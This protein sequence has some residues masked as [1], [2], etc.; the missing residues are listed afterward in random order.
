[1]EYD[2]SSDPFEFSGGTHVAASGKQSHSILSGGL[3]YKELELLRVVKVVPTNQEKEVNS[4]VGEGTPPTYTAMIN[5]LF[6][7]YGLIT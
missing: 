7:W 2:C 1:M 4:K 6:L 5:R 3:T